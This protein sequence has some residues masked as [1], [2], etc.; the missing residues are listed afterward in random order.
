MRAE[1]DEPEGDEPA[2]LPLIRLPPP[3]TSCPTWD[4]E[5]NPFPLGL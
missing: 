2:D 5:S 4:W 3:G 1:G